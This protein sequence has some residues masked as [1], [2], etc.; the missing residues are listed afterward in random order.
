MV[1]EP[2]CAIAARLEP[3][4]LRIVAQSS[5]GGTADV[6]TT[7]FNN[8][9]LNPNVGLGSQ[10]AVNAYVTNQGYSDYH[11]M[12][13]SLRK[14]F[15]KG[16]KFA[17]DYTWSHAID[18]QSN[19]TNAVSEGLVFDAL[20]LNPGRGIADFDIHHL[21]NANAIWELPLGR[22]RTLGRNISKWA[23]L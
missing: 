16:F 3:Q 6:V 17:A 9:L 7:L 18:N 14:R 23:A 8:G 11:A 19:V 4:K 5:E 15:S 12:L 1:G 20:N 21:F 10:F 2:S 22:G 13:V